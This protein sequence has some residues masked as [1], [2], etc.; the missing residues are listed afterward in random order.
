MCLQR[1]VSLHHSVT[2]RVCSSARL[3]CSRMFDASKQ[4]SGFPPR[5]N[6]VALKSDRQS[7]RRRVVARGL[8]PMRGGC[9]ISLSRLPDDYCQRGPSSPSP[10]T[11]AT[12]LNTFWIT[13]ARRSRGLT[14]PPM[15]WINFIMPL[16]LTHTHTASAAFETWGMSGNL[17][18]RRCALKAPWSNISKNLGWLRGNIIFALFVKRQFHYKLNLFFLAVSVF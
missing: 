11:L 9:W 2:K 8:R 14:L 6:K 5:C 7:V 18:F 10:H 3:K 15:D 12:S 1:D 17:E 4:L 16:T 13:T